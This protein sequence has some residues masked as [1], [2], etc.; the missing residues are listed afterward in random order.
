MMTSQEQPPCVEIK[1]ANEA[2]IPDT[3]SLL[4]AL[5]TSPQIPLLLKDVAGGHTPTSAADTC[6]NETAAAGSASPTLGG[7]P[8]AGLQTVSREYTADANASCGSRSPGVFPDMTDPD[9]LNADEPW[10]PLRE[11][12]EY[13]DEDTACSGPL[14]PQTPEPA[15]LPPPP[16]PLTPRPRAAATDPPLSRADRGG[17]MKPPTPWNQGGY[18]A[19]AAAAAAPCHPPLPPAA[20][21]RPPIPASMT[22][23]TPPNGVPM[24]MPSPYVHGPVSWYSPMPVPPPH[25]PYP[26]HRHHFPAAAD[27]HSYPVMAAGAAGGNAYAPAAAA[28]AVAAAQAGMRAACARPN[29]GVFAAALGSPRLPAAAVGT[30]ASNAAHPARQSAAKTPQHNNWGGPTARMLVSRLGKRARV[31]TS[32]PSQTGLNTPVPT[33]AERW[34]EEVARTRP[35][36]ASATLTPQRQAAATANSPA[37]A[38][39]AAATAL[40]AE[41]EAATSPALTGK[42]HSESSSTRPAAMCR[43]ID[44]EKAALSAALIANNVEAYQSREREKQ[45]R[46]GVLVAEVDTDL[47]PPPLGDE[48][49]QA[50]CSSSGVVRPLSTPP[51]LRSA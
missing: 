31:Q 38:A 17:T 25:Q 16:P 21:F 30:A 13:E 24:H 19:A 18:A 9:Q 23:A 10:L 6:L 26:Y 39:L 28:A 27:A 42:S 32:E 22:F 7:L 41:V 12:G 33:S 46:Q 47:R 2:H 5:I 11:A 20:C 49:H 15:L 4:T 44:A 45:Q 37:S 51:K 35:Q 8:R 3:L 29:G 36:E 34:A 1:Q 14:L 43:G 50:S 48:V 40:A